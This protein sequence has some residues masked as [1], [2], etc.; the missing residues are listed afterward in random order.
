MKYF[1]PIILLS[2]A[3]QT[4]EQHEQNASNKY[5]TA[6][7]FLKEQQIEFW[8][9]TNR[10]ETSPL[11][12]HFVKSIGAYRVDAEYFLVPAFEHTLLHSIK[13]PTSLQKVLPPETQVFIFPNDA[14]QKLQFEPCLR[15]PYQM[16]ELYSTLRL[17]LI[18]FE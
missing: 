12:D 7:I 5:D 11:S 3:C 15:C 16:A 14:R 6:L 17:E 18:K 2:A 10:L 1:I 13:L 9:G 4:D 8:Q